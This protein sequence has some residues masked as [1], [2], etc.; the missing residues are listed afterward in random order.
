M[1]RACSRGTMAPRQLGAVGSQKRE[2]MQR[3]GVQGSAGATVDPWARLGAVGL[4]RRE[5]RRWAAEP[6]RAPQLE[7]VRQRGRRAGMAVW[8][9]RR[10]LLAKAP[11]HG[12]GGLGHREATNGACAGRSLRRRREVVLAR[13][14]VATSRQRRKPAS[15]QASGQQRSWAIKELGGKRWESFERWRRHVVGIDAKKV[16]EGKLRWF[17]WVMSAM[18]A[19]RRRCRGAR[20]T[21]PGYGK[22]RS[23]G[24]KRSSYLARRIHRVLSA[25]VI[26]WVFGKWRVLLTHFA[27]GAVVLCS[28]TRD[29]QLGRLRAL[30]ACRS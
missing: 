7:K 5:S 2:E 21:P 15:A 8:K 17:R 30:L 1:N 16:L 4:S 25:C 14:C 22:Q 13:G 6:E 23:G 10:W 20:P 12:R 26:R 3:V 24:L 19:S 9:S 27:A 11:G 28:C 29:R 18:A